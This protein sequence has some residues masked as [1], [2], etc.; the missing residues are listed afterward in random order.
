MN[1][2]FDNSKEY[3]VIKKYGKIICFGRGEG[4]L[5]FSRMMNS[6]GL[7]DKILFV[8]DN[9]ETLWGTSVPGYDKS[10]SVCPI[11]RLY[12]E[13]NYLLVIT[14]VSDDLSY[15]ICRQIERDINLNG[16]EVIRMMPLFKMWLDQKKRTLDL[17]GTFRIFDNAIIPKTI[18]YCWFGHNPIPKQYEEWMSSWKKY[19]P[20]YE[21]IRWDEDN[22]DVYGIPY[23][24]D[25]YNAGKWAFVS[26]YA[27]LDII[28]NYGGIYL[29]TDV[30]LI[31]PL[32]DLLYERGFAGY[33]PDERIN[34]GLG[35]GAIKGLPIIKQLMEDYNNRYF[36]SVDD[37][38]GKIA[39]Q[40][41]SEIQTQFL[42]RNNK[43]KYTN[44]IVD[45]D[46]LRVYPSPVL[47]G[48]NADEEIRERLSYT[49]HHYAGSWL[50]S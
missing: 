22:Y 23:I 30:E 36:E 37:R 4:F 16:I 27:R 24:R 39:I 9:D 43:W 31:K 50:N 3:E 28:Y 1:L 35:F 8:V 34:T 20:D 42:L 12:E 48:L 38:K 6:F 25:A 21:I 32:D 33:L 41:C 5:A 19:C 49:I 11:Y 45:M 15:Q 44:D 2:I 26:D 46:G 47:D 10:W 17:K 29:D 18:H 14:T 7:D 13:E 40:L